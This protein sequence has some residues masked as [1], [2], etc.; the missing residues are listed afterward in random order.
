MR[1][2]VAI[3]SA[4]ICAP[5]GGII[6]CWSQPSSDAVLP[7]SATSANRVLSSS[8]FAWLIGE[9]K[10]YEDAPRTF[11]ERTTTSA[12]RSQP[13]RVYGGAGGRG[14]GRQGPPARRD[15][16]A[17]GGGGGDGPGPRPGRPR[18][19][20]VRHPGVQEG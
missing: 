19:G 3:C 18:G 15:P 5:R 14:R 4:R 16:P 1:P 6:T 12:R 13:A 20:R 9:R 7:R 17:G 8:N 2:I 10:V 11:S